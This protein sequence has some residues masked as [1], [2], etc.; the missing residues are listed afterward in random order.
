MVDIPLIFL[1]LSESS[2]F[3]LGDWDATLDGEGDAVGARN[4]IQIS[5]RG[6]GLEVVFLL[7]QRGGIA[8]NLAKSAST[9]L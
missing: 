5:L 1:G 2:P 8:S 4:T 6:R 7:P 3:S 9:G